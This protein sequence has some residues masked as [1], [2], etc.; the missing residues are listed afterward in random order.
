VIT[1]D[2]A[3]ILDMSASYEWNLSCLPFLRLVLYLLQW[4]ALIKTLE[5]KRSMLRSTL[6]RNL[7]PIALIT[8]GGL[9]CLAI[10]L[11]VFRAYLATVVWVLLGLF[12]IGIGVIGIVASNPKNKTIIGD[13]PSRSSQAPPSPTTPPRSSAVRTREIKLGQQNAITISKPVLIAGGVLL[14][15]LVLVLL[16]NF[17]MALRSL[18]TVQ[19]TQIIDCREASLYAEEGW[20]FVSAYSYRL[21]DEVSGY[22]DH[23]DCVME[24]ERFIWTKDKRVS[25][26]DT[27][28]GGESTGDAPIDADTGIPDPAAYLEPTQTHSS[29]PAATQMP[30]PTSNVGAVSSPLPT[31]TPPPSPTS[32]PTATPLPLSPTPSTVS[33][34]DIEVCEATSNDT[35]LNT[36]V[37]WEGTIINT[38]TFEEEGLWFQVQW[39]NSDPKSECSQATFFVS[40]DGTN[41]FYEEDMVAVTGT[42]IDTTYKYEGES[43]QT[44]YSVVVRADD[45]KLF[46]EP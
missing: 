43:G 33:R 24:Q 13:A 32:R 2:V 17:G 4:L 34:T 36:Y 8:L 5:G 27:S 23:T 29:Q 16:C 31:W 40:Y 30:P 1:G 25:K 46:V 12:M 10:V 44:E 45:V 14:V 28:T 9:I 3:L 11:Y 38:P 18:L 19:K 21:G 39:T 35:Y 6:K 20:R 15:S 26:E 41:R 37:Q 7:F 42:I 22:T